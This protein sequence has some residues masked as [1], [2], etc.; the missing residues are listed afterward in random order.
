[1]SKK[2]QLSTLGYFGTLDLIQTLEQA[3]VSKLRP[4]GTIR[5]SK[6]FHEA[7]KTFCPQWK[8]YIV[9]KSC[10]LSGMQHIPKQSH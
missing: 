8:H 10:R 9:K 4:V 3:W 6:T 1:M 7:A 2:V 5:D